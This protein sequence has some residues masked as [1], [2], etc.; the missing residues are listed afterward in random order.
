MLNI[1]PS[2]RISAAD[3]L[4]HP[5]ICVSVDY[6]GVVPAIC[7]ICSR[8]HVCVYIYIYIYGPFTVIFAQMNGRKGKRQEK[9]V[10]DA[11]MLIKVTVTQNGKPCAALGRLFPLALVVCNERRRGR[12]TQKE[13][14]SARK[15]SST[16]SIEI[17][18]F[19]TLTVGFSLSPS[20]NASVSLVQSIGRRRSIAYVNSMHAVN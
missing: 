11:K 14:E 17:N 20:S 10:D 9:N 1:N 13:R 7:S 18:R 3:A 2:R 6:E 5:W 8:V 12:G 19:S 15:S 4:K 16:R